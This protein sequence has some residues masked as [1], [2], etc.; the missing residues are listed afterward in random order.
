[1]IDRR[2]F[3]REGKNKEGATKRRDKKRAKKR[4]RN[5]ISM[6]YENMDDPD[7]ALAHDA[8]TASFPLTKECHHYTSISEVPWDIQK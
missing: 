5:G 7:D 8:I 6:Q 2:N 1:V 4:A 3:H